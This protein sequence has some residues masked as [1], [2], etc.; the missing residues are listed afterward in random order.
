VDLFFRSTYDVGEN[1]LTVQLN[2]K[3]LTDHDDLVPFYA[4]PDGSRL[5]RFLEGRLITGS[6]TY[7]F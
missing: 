5:Y 3:D 4:N 7:S 6:V 2:I 1:Q